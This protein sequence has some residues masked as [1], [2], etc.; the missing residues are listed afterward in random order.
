[1]VHRSTKETKTKMRTSK[2]KETYI[3]EFGAISRLGD[4]MVSLAMSTEIQNLVLDALF[5]VLV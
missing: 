2:E 5:S 3:P 1:M 4:I